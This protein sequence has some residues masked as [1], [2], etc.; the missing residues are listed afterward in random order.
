MIKNKI[1]FC[2]YYENWLQA[3]KVGS[4]RPI[5]L[6]KYYNTLNWLKKIVPN[7]MIE[8]LNRSEYQ[9]IINSFA[10]Q[11]EKQTTQD[12]H[13]QVKSAITDAI[14]DGLIEKDPTHKVIIKGK[15]PREKKEK[16]LNLKELEKL[17]NVLNLG[18][19]INND[20]LI[21]LISKTG[22][23]FSEA[24]ALTPEDFDFKKSTININKTWNYKE[25]GFFDLTKNDSSIRIIYID[26]NL[27]NQFK[28]LCKNLQKKEPI[29]IG[30]NGNIYNSTVNDALQRHCKKANITPIS[31]H[32]LRHTHA[33]ILLYSGVSIASV[34]KRL[35]HSNMATTQRIYLH[36]ISELENKDKNIILK[37]L[38]KF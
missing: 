33:S 31:L 30:K 14:Y 1:L 2:D 37:S 20:W 32:G 16:F 28:T 21:Y 27:N 35:G 6:K 34:S 25:G 5:T 22:L 38:E 13:R 9:K 36:L 19:N 29:F 4:L 8:D 26:K 12:F 3:Y 17:K 11:H 10:E 24:V 18:E 7:L 23:R 15:K